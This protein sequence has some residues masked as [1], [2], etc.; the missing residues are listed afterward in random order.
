[1]FFMFGRTGAPDTGAPQT[2]A[3]GIHSATFSAWIVPL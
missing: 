3:V 2:R 1:M